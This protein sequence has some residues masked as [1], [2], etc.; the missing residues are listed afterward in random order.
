MTRR[1][2]CSTALDVANNSSTSASVE[3]GAHSWLTFNA[4]CSSSLFTRLHPWTNRSVGDGESVFTGRC[5]M[6]REWSTMAPVGWTATTVYVGKRS[7]GVTTKSSVLPH[8]WVGLGPLTCCNI[9]NDDNE[10]LRQRLPTSV[11][12]D[13]RKRGSR[14]SKFLP[15][16][17]VWIRLERP[18]YEAVET[19]SQSWC[20]EIILHSACGERVEPVTLRSRGCYVCKHFKN[21]LDKRWQRYGH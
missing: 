17:V 1:K 18:K 8:R 6:T 11:Q 2:R 13:D 20:P 14:S 10:L 4:C 5:E 7:A 12:D 16:V 21:L 9:S 3:P 15:A 19:T